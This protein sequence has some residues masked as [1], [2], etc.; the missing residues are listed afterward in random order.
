MVGNE[1]TARHLRSAEITLFAHHSDT[2]LFRRTSGSP[3]G[4]QKRGALI[5][6]DTSAFEPMDG[7]EFQED[8]QED[9]P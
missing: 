9:Y 4:G 5:I 3:F 1:S 8:Y 6:G 2:T 7:W